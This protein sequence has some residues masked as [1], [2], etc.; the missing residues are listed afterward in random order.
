MQS[1]LPLG[2]QVSD[3]PVLPAAE[4]WEG[5]SP[6]QTRHPA[7]AYRLWYHIWAVVWVSDLVGAFLTCEK[8]GLNVD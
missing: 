1:L 3:Q 2:L 7:P 6:P 4:G 5:W 8:V